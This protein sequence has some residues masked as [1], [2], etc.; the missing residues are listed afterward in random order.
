MSRFV[1]EIRM[2]PWNFQGL[3]DSGL[4]DAGPGVVG[5]SIVWNRGEGT[6]DAALR[7][8]ADGEIQLY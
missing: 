8:S 7:G 6:N 1:Q 5:N 4:F 2:R 3:S